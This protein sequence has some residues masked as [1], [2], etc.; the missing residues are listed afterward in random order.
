VTHVRY[1]CL[2]WDQAKYR[3]L[4]MRAYDL[5]LCPEKALGSL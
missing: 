1:S 2:V 4:R 5:S 3:C